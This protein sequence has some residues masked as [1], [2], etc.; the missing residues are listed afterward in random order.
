M[1]TL[2]LASLAAPFMLWGMCALVA[3]PIR[4]RVQK[5]KD[6][7]LKRILLM[8]VG[9]PSPMDPNREELLKKRY[10]RP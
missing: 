2:P 8:R 10:F 5:M 7:R 6:G 3:W 1:S 9:E 4:K